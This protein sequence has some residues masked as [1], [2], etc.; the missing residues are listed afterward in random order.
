VA[1]VI[2]RTY[3]VSNKKKE[4]EKERRRIRRINMQT[5]PAGRNHSSFFFLKRI[6]LPRGGGDSSLRG[7]G[8][9]SPRGSVILFGERKK[10]GLYIL[11]SVNHPREYGE[12]YY[13][14]FSANNIPFYK[15][16]KLSELDGE[17]RR[18]GPEADRRT[19]AT[20]GRSKRP[21]GGLTS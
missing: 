5:P 3:H 13:T 12:I 17:R 1:A 21:N 18:R 10:D 16:T 7:N 4:K 14:T 2:S 19:R 11:F 9:S 15:K 8:N 6:T 20:H